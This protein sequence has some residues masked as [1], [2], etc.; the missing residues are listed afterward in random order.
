[1]IHGRAKKRQT[2]RRAGRRRGPGTPRKP[3][4]SRNMATLRPRQ[5]GCANLRAAA[6][7]APASNPT[8]HLAVIR[9]CKRLNTR[10]DRRTPRTGVKTT[11]RPV[12]D[13]KRTLIQW[14]L[15]GRMRRRNA[16]PRSLRR[17]NQ[18]AINYNFFGIKYARRSR[19]IESSLSFDPTSPT[20]PCLDSIS[21]NTLALL[22]RAH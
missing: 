7:V 5:T 17:R 3:Q 14:Q 2:P 21:P 4:N 22:F 10:N 6:G 15:T 12:G 18:N 1:M 8:H 9:P 13:V 20:F 16:S 19:H 11:V